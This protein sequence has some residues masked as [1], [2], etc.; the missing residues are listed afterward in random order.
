M[1]VEDNTRLQQALKVGLESTGAVQ[2]SLV[3]GG[4]YTPGQQVASYTLS[5]V[6]TGAAGGMGGPGGMGRPR[7]P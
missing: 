5:S 6:V 7:R 3:S 2:D 4:T 1:I